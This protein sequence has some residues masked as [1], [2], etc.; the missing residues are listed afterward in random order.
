MKLKLMRLVSLTDTMNR[1]GLNFSNDT[2]RKLEELAAQMEYEAE[3]PPQFEEAP[4]DCGANNMLA[5]PKGS[6]PGCIH[7]ENKQPIK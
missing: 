3:H 6:V 7:R 5:H 4:C 1:Q 2:K